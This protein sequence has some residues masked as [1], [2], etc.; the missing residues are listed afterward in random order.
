MDADW[1]R[2]PWHEALWQQLRP[3]GGTRHHALLLRGPAGI[4]K[5]RLARALVAALL[6][7]R[8]G[9]DGAACGSCDS[10]DWLQ[11]G[12]HPDFRR[13]SS[14]AQ[15]QEEGEADTEG[16][17]P[18]S[19]ERKASQQI[20]IDQIRALASFL[21]LTTHRGGARVL[22]VDPAEAM[23]PAA[24]NALLKVL[25]EPPPGTRFVLVSSQP[26]RLA[27]TIL[28]RCLPVSVPMPER[29]AAL[30]WLRAQG[31]GEP[32]QLLANAAGRPLL[33]VELADPER[34]AARARFLALLAA[35]DF[36]PHAVADK[37]ARDTLP[38][39]SEWLQSWCHDLMVTRA[40]GAP[41]FHAD[42]TD[43]LQRL[44]LRLDPGALLDWELRLRSARREARQPVN[45][46]L[47]CDELLMRY[48][49]MF[50]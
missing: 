38:Q 36:D 27:P 34:S 1:Q 18:A 7:Q 43:A 13:L 31:L 32:E 12:N 41:R 5:G 40:G 22:L 9:A 23:N 3:D 11:A 15:L 42:Q 47:F 33:A 50:Y 39:W 48:A 21:S 14:A 44:A 28:S 35:P 45:A 30:A 20:T 6:C 24:A 29:P 2:L 19:S 4:G 17:E 49:A 8:P 37:A 46:R 16:G 10:C 26:R 25:E